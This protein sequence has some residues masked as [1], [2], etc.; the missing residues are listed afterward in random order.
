MFYNSFAGIYH[1]FPELKYAVYKTINYPEL[2]G[3]VYTSGKFTSLQQAQSPAVT[4]FP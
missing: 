4:K 1:I 3:K 2:D